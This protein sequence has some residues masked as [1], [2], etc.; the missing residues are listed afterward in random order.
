MIFEAFFALPLIVLAP[1]LCLA[2]GHA[3]HQRHQLDLLETV[4]AVEDNWV[5][6]LSYAQGTLLFFV[7]PGI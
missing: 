7:D 1:L 5:E 6:I 2:C 4:H 3:V